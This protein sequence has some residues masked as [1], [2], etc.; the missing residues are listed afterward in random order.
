M[1]AIPHTANEKCFVEYYSSNL[2]SHTTPPH[3][4]EL[5]KLVDQ[6]ASHAFTAL[7]GLV[8]T[9][10]LLYLPSIFI[11]GYVVGIIWDRD[12]Q[13][14]LEKIW[15]PSPSSD[16]QSQKSSW[17]RAVY[18]GLISFC[19]A[20]SVVASVVAISAATSAS[21]QYQHDVEQRLYHREAFPI[22]LREYAFIK[23]FKSIDSKSSSYL[24]S[25]ALKA[26]S[27]V[28]HMA[29]LISFPSWY[30]GGFLLG[31]FTN[32]SV[33]A[34]SHRVYDFFYHRS[35]PQKLLMLFGFGYSLHASLSILSTFLGALVGSE[36]S[37][38]R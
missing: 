19:A 23:A 6:V 35:R 38:Q 5:S 37:K 13:N 28:V 12:V 27:L 26:G 18:F 31:S 9:I 29:S 34:T 22:T 15:S 10:G 3:K 7:L 1:Q 11:R 30:W 25:T 36:W 14:I 20:G 33:E 32:D 2:T 8:N 16:R 17:G 24:V 4:N 21:L